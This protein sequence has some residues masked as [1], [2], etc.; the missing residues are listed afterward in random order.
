MA[1][2]PHCKVIVFGCKILDT[3]IKVDLGLHQALVFK[4]D[5]NLGLNFMYMMFT[6]QRSLA[7]NS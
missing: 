4:L 7:S 5:L 3:R 6:I 2:S 1:A